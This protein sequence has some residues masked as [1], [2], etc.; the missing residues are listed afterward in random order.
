MLPDNPILRALIFNH[1]KLAT[2]WSQSQT[3]KNT[4]PNVPWRDISARMLDAVKD[5]FVKIR[6]GENLQGPFT[7][8]SKYL[9]QLL[10]PVTER[11]GKVINKGVVAGMA[12]LPER[13]LI[14]L[15]LGVARAQNPHLE[16]IEVSS[17]LSPKQAARTLARAVNAISGGG[18]SNLYK[19]AED[20][21][22]ETRAAASIP[23]RGMFLVDSSELSQ[24]GRGYSNA[25][26]LAAVDPQTFESLLTRTASELARPE[27][28]AGVI[29][30]IF[31]AA[32]VI[33]YYGDYVRGGKTELLGLNFGAA[34]TA[35]LGITV[36][37]TGRSMQKMPWMESAIGRVL[38]A[39]RIARDF[40]SGWLIET[41]KWLGVAGGVGMGIVS[42]IQGVMEIKYNFGISVLMI[43]MGV[44]TGYVAFAIVDASL[45]AAGVYFVIGV[46]IAAALWVISEFQSN[47]V[48][49]WM[50]QSKLGK[51]SMEDK[52]P[53]LLDQRT[54]LIKIAN[55]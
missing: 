17:D 45:M 47:V 23:A 12:A 1:Q 39:L 52:F 37:V 26:K 24:M 42:I 27:I 5:T 13:R 14:A 32:T 25:Q 36:E 20:L 53:S 54:V 16:L 15:M 31:A 55:G 28:K 51:L 46:L 22:V 41:G 33:G 3:D 7:N 50:A 21:I 34:V 6:M 10:G 49:K 2:T 29:V 8:I 19:S 40:N 9:F 18:A 30:G 43:G 4:S 44:A 11:L 38:A 48:Q 35:F